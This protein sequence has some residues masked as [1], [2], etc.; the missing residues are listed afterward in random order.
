MKYLYIILLFVLFAACNNRPIE[1]YPMSNIWEI[2]TSW[3][4]YKREY[5]VVYNT[6]GKNFLMG[7]PNQQQKRWKILQK[8]FIKI[9]PKY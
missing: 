4:M 3:G 9:F 8:K 7:H 5:Y 2:Y 6:R 1:I